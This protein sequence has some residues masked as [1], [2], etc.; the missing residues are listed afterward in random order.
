AILAMQ[1][2]N[3]TIRNGLF[4]PA[5]FGTPVAGAAA[6]AVFLLQRRRQAGFAMLAAA[7]VYVLGAFVPT[8]AVNVPMNEALAGVDAAAARQPERLWDD[9]SVTWVWWNHLRTLSSGLSLLLV[10]LAIFCS[11]RARKPGPMGASF[12]L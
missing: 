8:F 2:I 6:G 10:G 1:G 3:A 12:R 9:Y 5:F 4:A 7:L 11:G